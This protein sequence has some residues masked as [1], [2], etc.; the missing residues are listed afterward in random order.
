MSIE[1]FDW[2]C[3]IISATKTLARNNALDVNLPKPPHFGKSQKG[4]LWVVFIQVG[5][6]GIDRAWEK[7]VLDKHVSRQSQSVDGYI[8]HAT[9]AFP[10]SFPPQISPFSPNR[11][12]KKWN[13][14]SSSDSV[15]PCRSLS[16]INI[17]SCAFAFA[18]G[19]GRGQEECP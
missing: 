3:S 8:R 1:H 17:S 11:L 14:L 5:V 10:S 16:A 2:R 18:G 13:L 15:R 19:C 12:P 4:W 6:A 9:L 7:R